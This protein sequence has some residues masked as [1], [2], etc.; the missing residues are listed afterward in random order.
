MADFL[1][2]GRRRHQNCERVDVEARNFGIGL[3]RGCLHGFDRKK[4]ECRHLNFTNL[5]F[6]IMNQLRII[7]CKLNI[8]ISL[9]KF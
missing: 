4:R 5:S 7:I 9:P 3:D 8:I 1:T 2:D 6:I